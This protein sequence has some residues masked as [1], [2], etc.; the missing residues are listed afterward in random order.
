VR[1][2]S[3]PRVDQSARCPVREL[4]ISELAYPRVVQL[5]SV[6]VW[7]SNPACVVLLLQRAVVGGCERRRRQVSSEAIR[8]PA[9]E[10][11][12]RT[13]PKTRVRQVWTRRS[14]Q[15]QQGPGHRQR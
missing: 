7:C 8:R 3:S 4:A 11:H 5:P 10:P 1:E 12:L 6:A 13:T 9:A 15:S 2:L 14:A